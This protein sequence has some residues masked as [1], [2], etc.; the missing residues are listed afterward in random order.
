MNVMYPWYHD[1]SVRVCSLRNLVNDD[2]IRISVEKDTVFPDPGAKA[3]YRL[4]KFLGIASMNARKSKLV[5][6]CN[7]P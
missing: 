7:N 5:E 3:A 2:D 6:Y 1:Q 4:L